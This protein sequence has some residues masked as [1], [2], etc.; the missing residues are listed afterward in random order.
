MRSGRA[1]AVKYAFSGH[2]TFPF[3]YTWLPKG[4]GRLLNQPDL[5]TREDALVALGVGKNMVKS[6]RHWCTVTGVVERVD[7]GNAK[8]TDLGLR[9]FGDDGWDP[10]L[11]DPGTLWLLHWQLVREPIPASTWYLAFTRW[12][13]DR[14]GRDE[15]V[16]WLGGQIHSHL[17]RSQ[18]DKVPPLSG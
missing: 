6:I 2:E 14:F 10:Y 17:G 16:E 7:K 18:A 11:E 15:L 8:P 9:L 1:H 13:T 4:V 5:F 12:N 3:R